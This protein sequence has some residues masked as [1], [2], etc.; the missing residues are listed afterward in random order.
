MIY[1]ALTRRAM[2]IAMEAHRDQ[3]DPA[4]FPYI[5]H[6]I[7]VANAQ[8]D[9]R[10]AAAALL[11]D[12]CE[13]SEISIQDLYEFGM[14]EDVVQAVEALTHRKNEPYADYI[15]RVSKNKLARAVKLADLKANMDPSR[16][17]LCDTKKRIRLQ[18]K[19]AVYKL[20]YEKLSKAR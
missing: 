8:R 4:G 13:D 5:M 16:L 20:A 6:P 2:Q 1:T 14:P 17:V 12:V 18:Q 19:I 7:M 11:H 10:A 9:E 15:Q 3:T